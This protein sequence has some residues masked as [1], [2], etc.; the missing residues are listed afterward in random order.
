[1]ESRS[2][3]AWVAA[4]IILGTA[5]PV[6]AAAPIGVAGVFSG[7][8]T[9]TDVAN[10]DVNTWSGHGQA[11][12]GI[13][14]EFAGQIDGG[15]S[16]IDLGSGLSSADVF[17]VGGHAFWAPAMGRLGVTVNH[18]GVNYQF[19]SINYTQLGGFGEFYI[20]DMLTLG[21][22][23]GGIMAA[24]CV[25]KSA[26]ADG[27]YVSGGGTAYATPNLGIT[28]TVHYAEYLNFN[29][30]TIGILGELLLSDQMPI[31]VYAGYNYTDISSLTDNASQFTIGFK[32]YTSGN[33]VTLVEK[34]RNSVLSDLVRTGLNFKY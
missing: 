9:Y 32:F 2:K 17:H 24:N 11:A 21:M 23:A 10:T 22:N 27:A 1:M 8:Y 25:F 28:A 29:Y 13:T 7:Q 14:P 33:G 20:T 5:T 31:S 30:T 18:Q 19:N 6:L 34:H 26:C 3:I 15:Y 4:A 16:R 12:I